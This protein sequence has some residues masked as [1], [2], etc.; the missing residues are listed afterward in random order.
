MA[1]ATGLTPLFVS[2]VARGLS[3]AGP[4]TLARLREMIK[5]DNEREAFMAG[6]V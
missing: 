2:S 4:K 5:K 1:E 3:K 6:L